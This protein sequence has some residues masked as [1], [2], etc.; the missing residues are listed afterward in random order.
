MQWLVSAALA[1]LFALSASVLYFA[2][3]DSVSQD[4]WSD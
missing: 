2:L 1:P 3:R 4:G